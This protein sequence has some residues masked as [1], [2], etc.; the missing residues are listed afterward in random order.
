MRTKLLQALCW[1]ILTATAGSAEDDCADAS[2]L[3]VFESRASEREHQMPSAEQLVSAPDTTKESLAE[4]LMESQRNQLAEKMR[5]LRM[6][7]Q[8]QGKVTEL[9]RALQ[10]KDKAILMPEETAAEAGNRSIA[11]KPL[12]ASGAEARLASWEHSALAL[13]SSSSR[14]VLDQVERI[15]RISLLPLNA[16]VCVLIVLCSGILGICVGVIGSFSG[17]FAAASE[18]D[19]ASERGAALEAGALAERGAALGAGALALVPGQKEKMKKEKRSRWMLNYVFLALVPCVFLLSSLVWVQD[20]VKG[21]RVQGYSYLALV[22]VLML[23]QCLL[24]AGPIADGLVDACCKLPD[25]LVKAFASL[26]K[27][28]D[29]KLQGIL[30]DLIGD[31]PV[32]MGLNKVSSLLTAVLDPILAKVATA[33]DVRHFLPDA[34]FD[35][36]MLI[37]FLALGLFYLFFMVWGVLVNFSLL[38]IGIATLGV[39]GIMVFLLIAALLSHKVVQGFVYTFQFVVNRVFRFIMVALIPTESLDPILSPLGSNVSA[40]AFKMKIVEV[41]EL[42]LDLEESPHDEQNDM[43]NQNNGCC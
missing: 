15:Q 38:K 24:A 1:V 11:A 9:S 17:W 3:Q 43:M 41:L 2:L 29:S 26:G 16:V 28:I 10:E 27:D 36:S 40:T 30:I 23:L 34:F 18:D 32:T 20:M 14:S 42:H 19:A 6:L 33:M 31:S 22:N 25:V 21:S 12:N 13:V 7:S 4:A 37:P 39:V 5:S 8:L 35:V